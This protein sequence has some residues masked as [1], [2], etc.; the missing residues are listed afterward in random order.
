MR[1]H[2]HGAAGEVTGSLH[3]VEAAGRRILL[4][5]GMIQGSPEA[6][7]RN[8]DPFPFDAARLDALLISHA[9]IDHIGRVPLLVKRGF[10]GPI[11]AQQATAE[12]MPIML[13]D[14]ASIAENEAER[15]NRRRRNHET[16]AQP[17][18]TR[19]D[20]ETAMRRVKSLEYD[21]RSA[22]LPGIEIVLRDAGHILGSSIVELF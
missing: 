5:C 7:R 15:A 16:A 4:D 21:Q 9:H 19:Q 12:L 13:L 6:E 14:A 11:Y 20:V 3:E 18:Y 22:I 8:S 10:D 1:V 2:F 17:L